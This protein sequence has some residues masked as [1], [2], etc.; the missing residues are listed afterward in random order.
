MNEF[1]PGHGQIKQT[2]LECWK[3]KQ[4]G[5]VVLLPAFPDREEGKEALLWGLMLRVKWYKETIPGLS[6]PPDSSL[7]EPMTLEEMGSAGGP[8]NMNWTQQM[9][10]L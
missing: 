8:G 9:G 5:P 3:G 6:F 2:A 7:A 10:V 1:H 4:L